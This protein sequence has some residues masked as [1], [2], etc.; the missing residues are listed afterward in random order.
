MSVRQP[1]LSQH[2]QILAALSR[3]D[4]VEARQAMFG[5]VREW[6]AFFLRKYS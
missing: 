4:A 6:K 1:A 2:Q 5:H 3:R